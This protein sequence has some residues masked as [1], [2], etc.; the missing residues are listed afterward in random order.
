MRIAP[1]EVST[2]QEGESSKKEAAEI[3]QRLKDSSGEATITV[4]L[5]LSFAGFSTRREVQPQPVES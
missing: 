2:I 3:A 5:M 1:A 4:S